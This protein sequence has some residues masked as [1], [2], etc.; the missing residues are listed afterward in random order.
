MI[1]YRVLKTI[2]LGYIDP[3]SDEQRDVLVRPGDKPIGFNG[4][5]LFLRRSDG[6]W[7]ESI[8]VTHA[9]EE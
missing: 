7:L 3:E 2:V 6:Q 9:I 5:A 4:D 1:E 8:T